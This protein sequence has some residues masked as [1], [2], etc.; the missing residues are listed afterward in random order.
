MSSSKAMG[1][2]MKIRRRRIWLASATVLVTILGSAWIGSAQNASNPRLLEAER[3]TTQGEWDRAIETL[4][5]LIQQ[6]GAAPVDA[7]SRTTLIAAYEKR[8]LA[9]LQVGHQPDARADFAALLQLDPNHAMSGPS[10]GIIGLFEDTRKSTLAVLDLAIAPNDATI[11]LEGEKLPIP[12]SSTSPAVVN[13]GRQWL[14]AGHYRLTVRRPGYEG[15]SQDVELVPGRAQSVPINLRRTSAVLFIRTVPAGVHVL[16]DGAERGVTQADSA[17]S[18]RSQMLAIEGLEPRSMPYRVRFEKTCYVPAAET[19][20]VLALDAPDRT[21]GSDPSTVGADRHYDGISLR[22]SFGTLD[23]AADQPDAVVF[24]DGESRGKAGQPITDVCSGEHAIDIRA[25]T[26]RFFQRVQIE[27]EKTTTVKGTLLPTFA[28]RYLPAQDA[29]GADPKELAR[30]IDLLRTKN[31][32]FMT[33]DSPAAARGSTVSTEVLLTEA[34]TLMQRF[35][36][37]GIA[38]L[39]RVPPA[40]DG[41]DLELTLL[42]RGSSRPDVLRWSARSQTSVQRVIDRLDLQIPVVRTSLGVDAVDVLRMDGAVVS[43]V[44]P[45]GPSNGLIAAGDVIVGVGTSSIS[46][47]QD[48]VTVLSTM[49]DATATVRLRDKSSPVTV[50][51]ARVPAVVNVRD[52]LPFNVVATELR[53]RLARQQMVRSVSPE[54]I[55]PQGIRLNIGVALMALGNCE[56]A[57]QTFSEVKLENRRGVSRGTLDYLKGTCL[58]QSGQ[59]PEARA[60]FERASQEPDA[61][62]T[63]GGPTISHLALLELG[64]IGQTTR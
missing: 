52:D 58:K 50:P 36:T 3:L 2:D 14:P 45:T 26:G 48:L 42:A 62:L 46:T 30:S 22:R 18:E 11:S 28:L 61:V 23:V 25:A 10:P 56:L 12:P 44:D 35:D 33:V 15:V 39:T 17:G 24:I 4:T 53:A 57:L 32:R 9:H 38:V 16:I 6:I 5:E 8:A 20:T 55:R 7:E 41:D 60:H 13:Q 54:D 27:F 47:V 34:N 37:Q 40:A 63:E 49:A 51:L 43:A 21:T 19:F 59:L 64:Q 29:Q 1:A 31:L